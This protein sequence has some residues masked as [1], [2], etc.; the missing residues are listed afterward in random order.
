MPVHLVLSKR[1]LGWRF[2]PVFDLHQ[3]ISA[4][5]TYKDVRASFAD[6]R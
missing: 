1:S 3:V 6:A 2:I 4:E 5:P